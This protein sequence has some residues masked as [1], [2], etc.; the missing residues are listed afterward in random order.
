MNAKPA[1]A[2]RPAVV[3]LGSLSIDAATYGSQGNAVLGIRDSGKTY[4]AT[5]LA[6]QLFAAGVPF[7]VFDPVGMWRFLRVPGSGPGLPVVVAGGVA[8]DLALTPDTAP[9]IVEAAMQNG[10]SLILDLFSMDLTKA[11]WR[12]IVRDSV[13]LLLHKNAAHGLRHVFIEE[14]HEFV[15]QLV[16]DGLVYAEMEKLATMG[17]NARLGYTL[18]SQRS[19]QLNKAVLELCEN[20]F[21]HRQRGRNSLVSLG[22]WLNVGN[23]ADHQAIIRTLSTLPT[24]ECWAWLGG[25][26]TPV[27]IKVPAKDSFHPDRRVLRGGS[28]GPARGLVDVGAFVAMMRESLPAPGRAAPAKPSGKA[29]RAAP[30][31]DVAVSLAYDEGFGDGRTAGRAEASEEI[32]RLNALLLH[33][34][35][36]LQRVRDGAG[37]VTQTLDESL[38]AVSGGLAGHLGPGRESGERTSNSDSIRVNSGSDSGRNRVEIETR[39]ARAPPAVAAPAL[40]PDRKPDPAA[41]GELTGAGARLLEVLLRRSPARF[42]WAQIATLAGLKASGGYFNTGVRAL[43]VRDLVEEGGGQVWASETA[44]GAADEPA[45]PPQT[46]AEVLTM[47]C[48]KLPS[49]S[50]AMLR[51]LARR[52]PMPRDELAEAIGLQPRGGFW[53]KGVAALRNNR[54]VE[55]HGGVIQLAAELTSVN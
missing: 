47:W 27:R 37:L 41:A 11:D 15:P 16:T 25:S 26:D 29:G 24:G 4:T 21:L 42:T 52:G 31:P 46:P 48:D 53:N 33:V 5:L 54:L 51:M 43:R 10:V 44:I 3:N 38:R 6:E 50:P 17:G 18:V 35:G 22:K 20:L 14:A 39:A 30:D 45:D 7:T 34:A 55:I 49:P 12:R 32:G 2:P 40:R 13:K 8:G 36:L 9:A 19:E 1:P 23:V 28:E